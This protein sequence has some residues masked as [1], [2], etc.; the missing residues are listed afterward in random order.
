MEKRKRVVRFFEPLPTLRLDDP[1]SPASIALA[2][3]REVRRQARESARAL[4]Q[5][6]EA[7]ELDDLADD[8][9]IAD[10]LKTWGR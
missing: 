3:V 10:L 5:A 2:R 9:Q 6:R 8:G 7:G 4:E 1:T